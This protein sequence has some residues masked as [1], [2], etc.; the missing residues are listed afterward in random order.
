M[1]YEFAR[2]ALRNYHW[3]KVLLQ[4]IVSLSPELT[5]SQENS[6]NC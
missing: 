6:T 4:K 5:N 3:W 2:A 1:V